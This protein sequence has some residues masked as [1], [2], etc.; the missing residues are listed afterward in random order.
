[1]ARKKVN[2][3]ESL[4]S[5]A[6]WQRFYPDVY[7]RT[8]KGTW[9]TRQGRRNYE[10]STFNNL[11]G[12]NTSFDDIHKSDGDSPYLRNVRYMG[13]KQ[14][15]QRAQVTSRN[16]AELHGKV[17]E[18]HGSRAGMADAD[19]QAI[20]KVKAA[21]GRGADDPLLARQ[22]DQREAGRKLIASVF[23]Y[24]ALR[25]RHGSSPPRPVQSCT[26]I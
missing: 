25:P 5:G 14:E 9:Q 19:F 16:G 17:V 11:L 6:R 4:Y 18:K 10:F 26:I 8:T 13:E 24:G 12:L 7:T 22:H 3:Y 20:V 2:G 15:I 1:M 21:A 23:H